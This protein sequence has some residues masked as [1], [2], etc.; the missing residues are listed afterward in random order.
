MARN[1]LKSEKALRS[2]KSKNNI[3]LV[4][5]LDQMFL[6]A[7]FYKIGDGQIYWSMEYFK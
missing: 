6:F 7:L 3:R 1:I 2:R 5:F 4:L